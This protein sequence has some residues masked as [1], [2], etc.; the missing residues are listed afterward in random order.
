MMPTDQQGFIENLHFQYNSCNPS[1]FNLAINHY[2]P[3]LGLIDLDLKADL[4]LVNFDLY[5]DLLV[6][7][8]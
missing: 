5:P 2:W 6:G 3:D 7:S 4:W 8:P 1:A